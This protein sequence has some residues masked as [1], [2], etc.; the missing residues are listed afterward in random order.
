MFVNVLEINKLLGESHMLQTF[1][2]LL[3]PDIAM[4]SLAS[5]CIYL[6]AWEKSYLW[7]NGITK[8]RLEEIHLLG[9]AHKDVRSANIYVSVTA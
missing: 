9:I 3:Y 5:Q 1:Q 2:S 7:N 4:E 8:I 6:K